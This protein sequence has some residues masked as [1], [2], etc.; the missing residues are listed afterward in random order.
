MNRVSGLEP[1]PVRDRSAEASPTGSS[2]NVDTATTLPIK[3]QFAL[4]FRE[5]KPAS[6]QF[7][8]G[9]AC[10]ERQGNV[11]GV[12]GAP[13]GASHTCQ[14]HQAGAR[15]NQGG[16]RLMRCPVRSQPG[17]NILFL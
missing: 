8:E 6:W 3:G 17:L 9:S 11:A 10:G 5:K 2:L 16:N 7:L 12:W 13:R 4:G 15:Q 14:H 1:S